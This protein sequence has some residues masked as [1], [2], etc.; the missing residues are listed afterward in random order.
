MV[1]HVVKGRDIHALDVTGA[2]QE[3]VLAP[4][5]ALCLTIQVGKLQHN[6]LAVTDLKGVDKRCERLRIV[7]ART[8]ADD[9]VFQTPALGGAH[10]NAA[11]LEHI[12]NI[13]KGQ[14]ILQRKAEDVQLRN[15]VSALQSIERNARAA[16]FLL[17]INP[18]RKDTLAPDAVLCIEQTV[19]NP[20]AE[21]RH[22]DLVGI[23]KAH[24]EAQVDAVRVLDNTAPFAADIA[25]RL[26]HARK[27]SF[28]LS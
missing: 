22:A 8:A 3:F 12:E 13:G 20:A 24:A 6:L 26:L 11:Q 23:G 17:H 9:E 21:M 28:E 15:A 1:G 10:G 25:G 7:R 14:F 27:Y 19:Q 18:R 5:L 2:A 16:H 4:S